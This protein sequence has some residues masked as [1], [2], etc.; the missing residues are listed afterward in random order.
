MEA[1][2]A[3]TPTVGTE[4]PTVAAL[5]QVMERSG[6]SEAQA[7]AALEASNGDVNQA[8]GFL[9]LNADTAGGG[10]KRKSAQ[11]FDPTPPEMVKRPKKK[12]K[13]KKA[14]TWT[15]GGGAPPSHPADRAALAPPAAVGGDTFGR[16]IFTIYR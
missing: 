9:N 8:V 3:D 5:P 13:K 2:G 11:I 14:R 1:A 4:A 10:R 16:R 15:E 12:K 6:R 7:A